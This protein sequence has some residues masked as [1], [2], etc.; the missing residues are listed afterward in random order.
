MIL[1]QTGSGDSQT[2]VL[3]LG[4]I[5]SILC[6]IFIWIALSPTCKQMRKKKQQSNMLCA[7]YENDNTMRFARFEA[8]AREHTVRNGQLVR[9]YQP[10]G[11]VL[12]G[13]GRY[14]GGTEIQHYTSGGNGNYMVGGNGGNWRPIDGVSGVNGASGITP[15]TEVEPPTQTTIPEPVKEEKPVVKRTRFETLED[16]GD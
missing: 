2:I 5:A 12:G 10:R 14:T 1:L 13:Q 8:L 9:A 6:T 16:I 4:I 3:V 11:Q 15:H 7:I